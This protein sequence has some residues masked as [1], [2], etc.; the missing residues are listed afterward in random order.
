MGGFCVA[1][2]ARLIHEN[3]TEL[4]YTLYIV[5]AVQEEIGLRGAEMVAQS[6]KPNVAI[7]TDVTH[8]TNTPLINKKEVG[9]IKAG[10]ALR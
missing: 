8:D 9:D 7:V 3:K 2:V 5:N 4:P 6:I 10:R 1:E